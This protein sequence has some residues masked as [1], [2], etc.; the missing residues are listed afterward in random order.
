[1][2]KEGVLSWFSSP[3][4]RHIFEA[5]Q[6]DRD[7]LSKLFSLA[8][9]A[10][11]ALRNNKPFQ[12]AKDQSHQ[13]KILYSVFYEASTRTRFSFETAAWRLGMN[14]VSSENA[15]VFSSATKGESLFDTISVLDEY[16]P[17]VIVL[18]HY[19]EGAAQLA[20]AIS[21]AP[22][23]NAGDGAGQHPTQALLDVYTIY[24]EIGGIDHTTVVLGGDLRFGRTI[25]S[26]AYLLGKFNGV[27]IIFVSHEQLRVCQDIL[28][29]LD[30]HDVEYYETD[31]LEDAVCQADVVY[32]T[33]TQK[34]RLSGDVDF[35]EVSN[36]FTIN[37]TMMD[38]LPEHAIVMHPLPRNDEIAE[39]VDFDPRAAYFRQAGYGLPVRMVLL[40]HVLTP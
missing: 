6:F 3:R 24:R 10:A 25:R 20:S 36:R 21:T 8:D 12:S 35:D 33:R 26:L 27:R 31:E 38:L 7:D 19:E 34:E 18:R 23:I 15:R 17:D 22:I 37:K 30:R 28:D 1:M 9:R 29:Y 39:E 11:K 40:D 5:Q 13:R 14:V 16:G 4:P 2:T 32:W